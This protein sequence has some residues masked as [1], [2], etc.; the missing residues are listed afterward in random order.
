MTEWMSESQRRGLLNS[1]D[2]QWPINTPRLRNNPR[3]PSIP[4]ERGRRE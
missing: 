2:K 4:A 3:N 1:S